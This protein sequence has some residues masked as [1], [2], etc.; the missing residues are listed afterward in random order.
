L[1][2]DRGVDRQTTRQLFLAGS[3]ATRC[4]GYHV[5]AR[6]ESVQRP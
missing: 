5:S 4:R 3:G 2:Y 1:G 6:S